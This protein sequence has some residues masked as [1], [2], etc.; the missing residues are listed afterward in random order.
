MNIE[1]LKTLLQDIQKKYPPHY[2][3]K[4]HDVAYMI[5]ALL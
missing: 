1:N 2:P 4:S 5:P 3:T